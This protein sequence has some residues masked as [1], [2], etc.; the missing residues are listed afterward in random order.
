MP[1]IASSSVH[2][3][4]DIESRA[5]GLFPDAHAKVFGVRISHCPLDY[6][7]CGEMDIVEYANSLRV[8]LHCFPIGRPGDVMVLTPS[9]S[10]AAFIHD[11]KKLR[12]RVAY[13]RDVVSINAYTQRL[14]LA[15]RR[16]SSKRRLNLQSRAD[17]VKE[18]FDAIC[19]RHD[20]AAAL[21]VV[22]DIR[23]FGGIVFCDLIVTP[24]DW[25]ADLAIDEKVVLSD[26]K[27][28]KVRRL[29]Q[30]QPSAKSP[31]HAVFFRDVPNAITKATLRGGVCATLGCQEGDLD[32][33]ILH[34]A[35]QQPF[36]CF[37]AYVGT[38]S[39]MG[40][41]LLSLASNAPLRESLH[42]RVLPNS[43]ALFAVEAARRYRTA[44]QRRRP[45]TEYSRSVAGIAERA[46]TI[47]RIISSDL[48]RATVHDPEQLDPNLCYARKH[49]RKALLALRS[50]TNTSSSSADVDP[51]ASSTS[52]RTTPPPT[53]TRSKKK[54][55][56]KAARTRRQQQR[57][58]RH[59]QLKRQLT[60]SPAVEAPTLAPAAG[61][62]ARATT[63]E[64]V[65]QPVAAA[66][67]PSPPAPSSPPRVLTPEEREE[68]LEEAVFE[69]LQRDELLRPPPSFYGV[70]TR[71][72]KAQLGVM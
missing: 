32:V 52:Q 37:V 64:P 43:T 19:Q 6:D 54:R 62:G 33:V 9:A 49:I 16:C 55:S 15:I 1:S 35:A 45:A 10:L 3:A 31:V 27:W 21:C 58:E 14:C 20:I 60:S 18:V 11:H 26:Q 17:T 51:T 63:P 72:Q 66:R 42:R 57:R 69:T 22:M 8:P 53:A 71:A 48:G 5:R 47:C 29:Q 28:V 68:V 13:W 39:S 30:Q 38:D 44:A 56:R 34:H 67:T 41:R 61:A 4:C 70:L 36:N 2:V 25:L 24:T 50:V 23:S 59:Q 12:H 40:S 46:A 65:T 7:I